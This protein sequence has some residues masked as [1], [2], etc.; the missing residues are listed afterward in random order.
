MSGV[1]YVI[2]KAHMLPEHYS[3]VLFVNGSKT[4]EI[5]SFNSYS[6]ERSILLQLAEGTS[7]SLRLT[8]FY[9]K[10]RRFPNIS[11]RRSFS[12]AGFLVAQS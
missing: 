6:Q 1:Y 7:L 12:M 2:F 5:P 4:F 10:V 3:I 9:R 11:Y 8:T